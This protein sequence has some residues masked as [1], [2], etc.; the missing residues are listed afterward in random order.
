MK[1]ALSCRLVHLERA[2]GLEVLYQSQLLRDLIK[3]LLKGRR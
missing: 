1:A 3:F 2:L